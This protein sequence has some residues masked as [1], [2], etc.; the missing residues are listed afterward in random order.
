MYRTVKGCVPV[1]YLSV[2]VQTDR[3]YEP[4]HTMCVWVCV[5]GGGV[6]LCVGVWV[7]GCVYEIGFQTYGN[8]FFEELRY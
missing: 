1:R 8:V 4:Y 6:W 7:C 2:P 5:F 3:R